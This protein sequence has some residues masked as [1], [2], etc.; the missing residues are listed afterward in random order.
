MFNE[1]ALYTKVQPIHI[2]RTQLLTVKR[3]S[4]PLKRVYYTM[5]PNCWH[6]I[7]KGFLI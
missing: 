2:G 7:Y 6:F 5:F 3:I 4:G 1:F